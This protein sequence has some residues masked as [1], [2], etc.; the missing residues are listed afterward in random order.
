MIN[1]KFDNSVAIIDYGM[2]N[3]NSVAKMVKFLNFN[4]FFAKKKQ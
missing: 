1:T 4:P 2:G 3:I